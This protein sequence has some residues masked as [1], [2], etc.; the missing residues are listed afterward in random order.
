[1]EMTRAKGLR[2]SLPFLS[3]IPTFSLLQNK[4]KEIKTFVCA[5]VLVSVLVHGH[6][7]LMINLKDHTAIVSW[8]MPRIPQPTKDATVGLILRATVFQRTD[9]RKAFFSLTSHTS[10]GAN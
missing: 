6:N 3:L 4:P 8:F 10:S 5:F 2:G 9:C 7:G 1:M